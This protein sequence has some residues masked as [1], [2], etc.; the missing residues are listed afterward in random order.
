MKYLLPFWWK[1]PARIL[2]LTSRFAHE[3]LSPEHSR[4]GTGAWLEICQLGII[5]I[6]LFFKSMAVR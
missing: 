1:Y 3:L 4:H 2:A 5:L 6:A